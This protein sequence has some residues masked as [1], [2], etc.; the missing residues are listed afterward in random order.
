[1]KIVTTSQFDEEVKEGY[2]LVDCFA[3]WCGPCKM[4]SPFLDQLEPEYEGKVK[5]IKVNVD[6]DPDIASKYGV[7][8]I[9]DLII[10]KDGEVIK[11][12]VGFKNAAMLKTFIDS[13]LQ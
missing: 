10:L 6:N 4:L 2:V 3:E 5:F 9:P 8:S 13:A 7:M 12:E 11:N 1:M